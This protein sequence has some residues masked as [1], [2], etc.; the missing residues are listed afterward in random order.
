[1]VAIPR[2]VATA[3][4][5][6][7]RIAGFIFGDGN[8][9]HADGQ[10]G[11]ALTA[12]D[13]TSWMREECVRCAGILGWTLGTHYR[14][15]SNGNFIVNRDAI[16]AA[17]GRPT[18]PT[19]F[20]Y[21]AL[22]PTGSWT[23][24]RVQI[25]AFLASVIETEGGGPGPESGGSSKVFDDA[26]G[27]DYDQRI[28][29]LVTT[30]NLQSLSSTRVG[31]S[32]RVPVALLDAFPLPLISAARYPGNLPA[33]WPDNAPPNP[34][35]TPP[36]VPTGLVGLEGDSQ[37]SL[38]WGTVLASDLAGYRLYR[39][40][41]QIYQGTTSA[42]LDTGLTN[43]TS[44]TY[45]V[46]SYDTTGNE[47]AQSDPTTVAPVAAPVTPDPPPDAPTALAGVATSTSVSLT[48][49]A[50]VAGDVAGYQVYRG[51]DLLDTVSGTS[52]VDS[53]LTP[54]TIYSYRIVAVDGAG[55]LSPSTAF[56]SVTTAAEP[57][58]PPDVSPPQEVSRLG[59]PTQYDVFIMDRA[60][61]INLR[62][63]P[64]TAL[65]WGRVV[66]EV[67]TARI[68][69][70]WGAYSECCAALEGL[71][72]YAYEVGIY[73]DG[74]LVWQGPIVDVDKNGTL[75]CEDKMGW[76]RV[77]VIHNEI[78]YPEPGV[79]VATIFN[80]V[81]MDAMQP[82]NVP[83]LMAG[84]TPTG[85]AGVREYLPNPPQY[86]Y[87]AITELARTGVDYT[88]TGPTLVAGSFIV[89]TPTIAYIT[90]QALAEEPDIEM[91]G[92]NYASRI[93][94]TGDPEQDLIGIYGGI[95]AVAGLVERIAQEDDIDDQASL[96]QN[97]RSRWEL[98]AQQFITSATLTL[99]QDA[100]TPI[101]LLV[102]GAY[103]E[104]L[105]SESC[106]PLVGTFRIRDVTVDVDARGGISERVQVGIEPAGTEIVSD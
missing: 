7:A 94:V 81:V 5:A 35:V 84:A 62:T 16:Y 71:R 25:E 80:A 77:R 32:T 37:I 67:S 12:L 63:V 57:Q 14:L 40:G 22:E 10:I 58:T 74:E 15:P 54:N 6:A 31:V 90:L 33:N 30:L 91:L 50:S 29:A 87:D 38:S 3:P 45:R 70:D 78:R 89:P 51:S 104:M 72:Q 82:D 24:T 56:I 100:P 53:G 101:D 13:T 27:G 4:E 76:L 75:S 93:L 47:S 59:C 96:N 11:T 41:V 86:A 44:Y 60:G 23:P 28:D 61:L 79:D 8:P 106:I 88:V 83:G 43:G 34:D 52:Y 1:M 42:F 66:D 85:V 73:R 9:E 95:D 39:G 17:L 20:Y 36:P 105:V 18:G 48:W 26:R 99:A 49:V 55:G 103:I 46:S 69:M 64:F 97:A 21:R 102:G 98:M 2:Y 68:Q 65:R 92:S 19:S